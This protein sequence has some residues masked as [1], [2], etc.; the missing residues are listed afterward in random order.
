[1]RVTHFGICFGAHFF[2]SERLPAIVV[3]IQMSTLQEAQGPDVLG[4]EIPMP[5]PHFHAFPPPF[6]LDLKA[7]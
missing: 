7:M 5:P 4:S 3:R 6:F 2:S 1:M